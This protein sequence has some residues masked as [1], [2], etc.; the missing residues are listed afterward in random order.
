MELQDAINIADR[1]AT[2]QGI[3]WYVALFSFGH[4]AVSER[5]LNDVNPELRGRCVYKVTLQEEELI[6]EFING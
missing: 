3:P 4:N 1:N 5:Y 6:K 2:R